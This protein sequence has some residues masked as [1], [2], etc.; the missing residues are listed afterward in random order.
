[1]PGLGLA[2]FSSGN[3]SLVTGAFVIQGGTRKNNMATDQQINA[4]RADITPRINDAEAQERLAA[5]VNSSDD[6]IIGKSL[7]GIITDWNP[8]AEA[9]FG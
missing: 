7:A 1:M 6:A 2:F 3:F 9:L 8:G 5:I 4:I